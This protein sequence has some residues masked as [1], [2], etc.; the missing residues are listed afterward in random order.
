MAEKAYALIQ[1]RRMRHITK[2]ALRA[3]IRPALEEGAFN[4]YA[5]V[6]RYLERSSF[7]SVS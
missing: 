5:F 7:R 2:P 4:L 6:E 1:Q 3:E